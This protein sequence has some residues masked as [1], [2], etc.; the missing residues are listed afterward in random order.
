MTQQV[1]PLLVCAAI[2]QVFNKLIPQAAD[3]YSK[4]DK[5]VLCIHL[6]QLNWPLYFIFAPQ[7]QI[8][9]QY[10]GTV[11]AEITADIMTLY[12]LSEG[13]NLTELIKQNKLII[14]GDLHLLHNFSHFINQFQLDLAE[15]L[16]H[17]IGDA[18]THWVINGATHAKYQLNQI[19]TQSVEHLAMLAT[20]EYQLAAHKIQLLQLSDSIEQLRLHTDAIEQRINYLKKRLENRS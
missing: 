15:P 13:D 12:Q 11:N 2:E 17:Y 8:L 1:A 4:L 18:A 16:S 3:E 6:P 20:E 7:I 14:E 19:V 9:S 10:S 5:Q